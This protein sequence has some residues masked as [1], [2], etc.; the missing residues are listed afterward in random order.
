MPDSL[1]DVA[2]HYELL[3]GLE[4][5]DKQGKY[6]EFWD[7]RSFAA[8][9][10]RGKAA[11]SLPFFSEFPRVKNREFQQWIRELKFPVRP[12]NSHHADAIALLPQS[13]ISV[14]HS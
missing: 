7:F 4:F 1:A 13:K 10:R 11:R 9:S 2:V 12:L 3:S 14:L 6:R 8:N 5:P